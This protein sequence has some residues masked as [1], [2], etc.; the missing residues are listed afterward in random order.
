ME[1]FS[2]MQALC[3][4]ASVFANAAF[5]LLGDE[6]LNKCGL[7]VRLLK[8]CPVAKAFAR[9]RRYD[10]VY[11]CGWYSLACG[12]YGL[13]WARRFKQWMLQCVVLE[14]GENDCL[15]SVESH[16]KCMYNYVGTT[17]VFR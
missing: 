2:A 3:A 7:R 12:Q 4:V 5:F 9:C 6:A 16:Y 17:L 15:V 11:M 13:A 1:A 10:P 14:Y 8:H